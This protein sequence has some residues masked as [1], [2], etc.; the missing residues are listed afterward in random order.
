MKKINR[1]DFLKIGTFGA[2][3]ISLEAQFSGLIPIFGTPGR[4]VSRY[5]KNYRLGIPSTCDMCPARCG[6][7][8]FLNYEILAAV[9]G[10]PKH[11]N[12]RG[13][14]CARG[15]AGINQVYDPERI[16]FPLKRIGARGKGKWKKISW[17]EALTEILQRIQTSRRI[18]N[19]E[20]LIFHSE[21]RH[22]TG[23]SRRFLKAIGKPTILFSDAFDLH[24]KSV[25][26]KM[27]W[28]EEFEIVDA[29]KSLY[30][31]N[32]GGNPYESH[33]FFVNFNQR[34]I[35]GKIDRHAK[36]VTI[37]P[38]LSNTAG[39]SDLWI[40]IKP[41]TDAYL[42][43]AMANVIM[44]K[45]LH[46]AGFISQWTNVSVAE[47]K[48]YL[49]GFTLEKAEKITRV[50]AATIEKI[51][52]E[53]A[54][55]QP[56]VAFS[57]G[58]V[59]KHANGT[60]NERCIMLLNAIV[61]NIDVEGGYCLPRR[62]HLREYDPAEKFA[63]EKNALEIFNQINNGEQ[64]V[65]FY[66]A[67]KVNP[68]Y[69]N[70]DC[71]FTR[72]VMSN[73]K[74]MPFTVVMDTKMSETA[75]LADMVLPATTFLESWALDASPSFDMV[76]FVS[77]QQPIITPDKNCRP[78]YD[79]FIPL[80]NFMG[81]RVANMFNYRNIEDYIKE[82]ATEIPGLT[83]SEDFANLK[84]HGIWVSDRQKVRYR[85]YQAKGFKTPSK[86][87][88]I[89]ATALRKQGIAPLP[90]YQPIRE[91]IN[92]AKNELLL[93]PYH[94]NVLRPDLTNSKWLVEIHH[95][96]PAL[97]NR[98]T[99]R[100]LKIK[101]GDKIILESSVGKLELKAHITEGVHPD[102]VA[103]SNSLGHWEYGHIA[104]A[105]PFKSDD[106]DT[107]FIWWKKAGKGTNPNWLIPL[108]LDSL[109]KGQAWMDTKVTVKKA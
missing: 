50:P 13:R 53:F 70:P 66:F 42:A 60:E 26:Q 27:T 109:G 25:A 33:P 55:S 41:G 30:F 104:R 38:R 69:E 102:V 87:F 95:S 106:P 39:R 21:R 84:K 56:G 19:D 58:G 31:L 43:L 3:A 85:T 65:D 75:A 14:I 61:G 77:L 97:L 5:S 83:P 107:K 72:A 17:N 8:G 1:R 82:I 62:Y 24:N 29:A 71:N 40:P 49:A 101:E 36:L 68:V 10:N 2:T 67:Y 6:V 99:A 32:F 46:D 59:T 4:N 54:T 96:N 98:K 88:E 76:P 64:Q 52:V 100:K 91:H 51:A 18:G 89:A 48:N 15:I 92:L 11:L 7:I 20:K 37:D 9:Q 34:I 23:L 73:E 22:F 80:A 86:K 81:N 90:K 12:N 105:E 94:V 28:G 93:I 78:L 47:L 35:E 103:I 108:R 79:V 57:G 63:N 45:N 16:K 44:Q 74:L